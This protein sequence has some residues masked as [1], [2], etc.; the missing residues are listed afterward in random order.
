M[1]YLADPGNG[2]NGTTRV[3]VGAQPGQARHVAA[4]VAAGGVGAIAG[5]A[6][7]DR[8]DAAKGTS[9][10]RVAAE[11]RCSAATVGKWRMRFVAHQLYGLVDEDRPRRPASFILDQVEAL[12]VATLE[13][14]P[15]DATHWSRTSMAKKSGCRR[16][17]SVRSSATSASSHTRRRAQAVHRSVLPSKGSSMSS[18][19]TTT[20]LATAIWVVVDGGSLFAPS[21]TRRLTEEFARRAHRPGR[22]RSWAC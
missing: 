14:S 11:M 19:S 2:E 3:G 10:Q 5:I 21:V 8:V 18:G 16:R 1:G 6:M 13:A 20:L 12:V 9:N 15:K 7:Q 22:C 4:W 17:R